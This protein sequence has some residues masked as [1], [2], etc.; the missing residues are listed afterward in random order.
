MTASGG[1][2]LGAMW[3]SSPL[4]WWR[5]CLAPQGHPNSRTLNRCRRPL[6]RPASP[7]LHPPLPWMGPLHLSCRGTKTWTAL[8]PRTWWHLD[9]GRCV[10]RLPRQLKPRILAT[11]VPSPEARGNHCPY[12]DAGGPISVPSETPSPPPP[13]IQSATVESQ[14]LPNFH[15][16]LQGSTRPPPPFLRL[17]PTPSPHHLPAISRA[18][19]TLSLLPPPHA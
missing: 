13:M 8:H 18:G 12:S 11:R 3:G 4:C 10:H 9:L 5:S 6:P 17:G 14:T 7:L 1:E 16:H 2:N 15:S 19:P